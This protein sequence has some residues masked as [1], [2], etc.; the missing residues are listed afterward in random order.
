MQVTRNSLVLFFLILS[1]YCFYRVL[2]TVVFRLP[3]DMC[4]ACCNHTTHHSSTKNTTVYP[5]YIVYIYANSFF[6]FFYPVLWS[7][8]TFLRDGLTWE[9][10]Q[11]DT[12]IHPQHVFRPYFLSFPRSLNPDPWSQRG[13]FSLLPTTVC[14]LN[15]YRDDTFRSGLSSLTRI[16]APPPRC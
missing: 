6:C 14:A 11:H 7:W 4:R 2:I 9:Q 10:P 8:T 12:S 1:Y 15:S 5:W 3:S 13:L 16:V